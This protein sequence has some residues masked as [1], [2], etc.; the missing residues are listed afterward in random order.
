MELWLC[1]HFVFVVLFCCSHIALV[2]NITKCH[3]TL[4]TL[5]K[6]PVKQTLNLLYY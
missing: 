5:E 2:P 6:L 1:L 4:Q 3:T